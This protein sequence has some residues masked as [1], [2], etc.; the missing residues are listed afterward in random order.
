MCLTSTY[1]HIHTAQHWAKQSQDSLS[2]SAGV[3]SP[4][5]LKPPLLWWVNLLTWCFNDEIKRWTSSSPSLSSFSL[6]ENEIVSLMLLSGEQF[7]SPSPTKI[8]SNREQSVDSASPSHFWLEQLLCFRLCLPTWLQL[9]IHN[10]LTPFRICK[11][12]M[13]W[14][15]ERQNYSVLTQHF[16]GRENLGSAVSSLKPCL[17]VFLCSE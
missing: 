11:A 14:V 3:F 4:C 15:N 6:I 8:T 12:N 7:S 13:S 2:I 1:P 16:W 10:S 17:S 9:H 5:A